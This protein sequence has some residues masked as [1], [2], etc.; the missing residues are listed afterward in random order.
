MTTEKMKIEIW[1]DVTCVHCY[2]A[3]RKFEQAIAQTNYGDLIAL[4]WRSFELAPGLKVDSSQTMYEFLAQYNNASIDQV[5]AVCNQIVNSGKEVGLT[6]NFEIAKP[7]NSFQAHQLS[8]LAKRH[9]LQVQ[10]EEILYQAHFIEG[11]NIDDTSTL[12]SLA[13]SIGLDQKEVKASLN[14]HQYVEAVKDDIIEAR[15]LG[16]KGVPYYQFNK[17]HSVSGVQSVDTYRQLLEKA[18][19]DWK[20]DIQSRPDN[21]EGMVCRPGELCD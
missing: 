21:I 3:K 9:N 14:S 7:A 11:K 12:L 19:T 2:I 5:K 20:N 18:I 10:A 8:H 17:K 6:Y 13:N 15:Q 1:S 4:E 16:I